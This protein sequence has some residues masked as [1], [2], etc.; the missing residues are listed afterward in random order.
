MTNKTQKRAL[1]TSFLALMLCFTMLF[2][3]T[4]AYFTDSAASRGN[5]IKSG[6]LDVALSYATGTEDPATTAWT[7][8]SEG[9]VF[10]YDNWEPGYAMARHLKVEN[11][12]SLAF[13]YE[14][15]IVPHGEV[16][17]LAEVIDVYYSAPAT[18]IES[19]DEA[20]LGTKIGTLA[21]LISNGISSDVL[22]AGEN[23]SATLVLK[24]REDATSDYEG[25]SIGSDFSIQVI[26]TQYTYEEDSFGADY[27]KDAYV[28]VNSMTALKTAIAEATTPKTIFI[29]S[30]NYELTGM[31]SIEGKSL[32]II[33]LG[34][35]NI[36]AT[37]AGQHMF[38]IQDNVNPDSDMI[39]TMK[40]LEL[41]RQNA[42]KQG[43]NVKYNVTVNL[44]NVTV[45]NA[46]QPGWYGVILD[47]GN[48]FTDG[49]CYDGTDTV[50]NM[51][52]CRID[53]V[54]MNALPN[55]V[56]TTNNTTAHLWYDTATVIG[57]I[58]KQ[59]GCQNHQN[60]YINGVNDG[61]SKVNYTLVSTAAELETAI[62][63]AKAN[64]ENN[65][66]FAN[67]IAGDVYAPQMPNADVIIDGKG[68]AFDGT[69][70]VDG[71]AKSAFNNP[72][73]FTL[74][75]INFKTET[76]DEYFIDTD[77]I[78]NRNNY[79]HNLI[80]ENCTFTGTGAAHYTAQAH[81]SRAGFGVK[82]VNCEFTGLHSIIWAAG[83]R[84]IVFEDIV[85]T[86]CLSGISVEGETELSITRADITAIDAYGYG[87]RISVNSGSKTIT[88]TD[89]KIAADAP[90]LVR[91][92]STFDCTLTLSGENTLVGANEF[93][94]AQILVTSANDYSATVAFA[95]STGKTVLNGVDGYI[96]YKG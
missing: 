55:G 80:I 85:A 11:K 71:T 7:D 23:Y 37:N 15:A 88:I 18:K 17:K 35:V 90:I 56:S 49:Q 68:F 72:E 50:V 86:D 76:A 78:G 53:S 73:T 67:D 52:N 13:R 65:I 74:K 40:N 61:Q 39:V 62:A 92:E 19:R 91:K 45:K 31:I 6:T 22:L 29:Q 94:N 5:V 8:A 32:S 3:L 42:K 26:A 1:V 60:L 54:G 77:K 9:A 44:E 82:F 20:A 57:T 36:T 43:I 10:N 89:S 79:A 64:E 70:K 33:G 75:N 47:N 87:V 38:T 41:D 63:A 93:G 95:P 66:V 83:T 69:I 96:V 30:G 12:G 34:D 24:M 4:Y 28:I 81:H 21:E 84:D 27:D 58:E 59:S 16:S 2:G 48:K 14:L 25:L 51:K 46:T